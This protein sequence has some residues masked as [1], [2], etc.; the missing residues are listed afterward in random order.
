MAKPPESQPSSTTTN[1]AER[2]GY[3]SQA[4]AATYLGVTRRTVRQMVADGRLIGYRAG[5]RLVRYKI[6]DLD[7]AMQPFGGAA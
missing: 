3:V 5:S 6:A 2:R 7:A 1:R 4:E